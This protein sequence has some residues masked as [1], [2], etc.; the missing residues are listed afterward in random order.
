MIKIKCIITR[1]KYE[2]SP[3]YYHA[4]NEKNRW[5]RKQLQFV[6]VILF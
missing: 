4:K 3:F 2:N 6:Y 1:F 5:N